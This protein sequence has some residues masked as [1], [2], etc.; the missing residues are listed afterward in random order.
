MRSVYQR[1][2]P[3]TVSIHNAGHKL[4]DESYMVNESTL[5]MRHTAITAAIRMNF[6]AHSLQAR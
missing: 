3:C 6:H 1:S 5:H 2:I 4:P